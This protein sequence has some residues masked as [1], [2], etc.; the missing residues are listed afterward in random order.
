MRIIHLFLVPCVICFD[1]VTVCCLLFLH[2][3]PPALYRREVGREKGE[4]VAHDLECFSGN[5]KLRNTIP[6]LQQPVEKLC[7]FYFFFPSETLRKLKILFLPAL[8]WKTVVC[9]STPTMARNNNMNTFHV[10]DEC[11]WK[12]LHNISFFLH[13]YCFLWIIKFISRK[14]EKSI[15][16]KKHYYF[17]WFGFSTAW[18]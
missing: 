2:F 15:A 13:K 5:I 6:E 17:V 16:T 11:L 18:L 12:Y 7:D 3:S 4:W 14:Y 8:D 9:E 1:A 10:T